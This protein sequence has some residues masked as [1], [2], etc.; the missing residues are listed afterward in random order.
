MLQTP[1]PKMGLFD[2]LLLVAPLRPQTF[3]SSTGIFLATLIRRSSPT[4]SHRNVRPQESIIFG[5]SGLRA[6]QNAGRIRLRSLQRLN[7]RS[8]SEII[9]YLSAHLGGRL[10]LARQ[11]NFFSIV[12]SGGEF[13]AI[14]LPHTQS[15]RAV[16]RLSLGIHFC[17]SEAAR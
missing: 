5:A 17:F 12:S 2:A 9:S 16:D 8:I 6:R 13:P 3:S 14:V 1:T 11:T 15:A 4:S 7:A 10:F